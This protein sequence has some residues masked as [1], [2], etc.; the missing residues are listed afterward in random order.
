[1]VIG[2]RFE[3]GSVVAENGESRTFAAREVPGGRQVLVHQILEPPAGSPRSSLR[4]LAGRFRPGSGPVI[5]TCSSEGVDYVV[6]EQQEGFRGLRELLERAPGAPLPPP[7]SGGEERFT[8]VGAWRVPAGLPTAAPSPVEPTGLSVSG[9]FSGPVTE[10]PPPLVDAPPPSPARPSVAGEPG[11]FTR[12]FQAPASANV[13]VQ[14][15]PEAA[16]PAVSQP[17]QFTQMFQA[18]APPQSPA[19]AFPPAAARPPAAGEPDEFTRYFQ[20]SLGSVPFEERGIPPPELKPAP[21]RPQAAPPPGEYT[22]LFQMPA[23]PAAPAPPGSGATQVFVTPTAAASP[24]PVHIQE[25]PSEFTRMIQTSPG[26]GVGSVP[27]AAAEQPRPPAPQ[28]SMA[29][30]GVPVGLIVLFASL[31][32]L[33]IAMVVYFALRH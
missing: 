4:D 30:P 20:S 18:P 3:L 14:A 10:Q 7:K 1:M 23:A 17:G 6:T 5:E 19:P 27:Q 22:R 28:P 31:A 26:P 16:P 12:M 24:P 11:E 21:P 15:P 8:R 9:I 33:A 2:G 32:V 25:G 13:P 29:K